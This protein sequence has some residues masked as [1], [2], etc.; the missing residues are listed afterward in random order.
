MH[1]GS[2]H[3][4][5]HEP[6]GFGKLCGSTV[7]C[8]GGHFQHLGRLFLPSGAWIRTMERDTH[9]LRWTMTSAKQTSL[10]PRNW[11]GR[12]KRALMRSWKAGHIF[13]YSHCAWV[14]IPPTQRLSG[15]DNEENWGTFGFYLVFKLILSHIDVG[16]WPLLPNW[17]L[18]MPTNLLLRVILKF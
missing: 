7:L 6:L 10:L 18:Y 8:V 16:E 4:G 13:A 1:T 2:V 11:P 17:W 3:P 14:S 12:G 9:P 15:G 5:T